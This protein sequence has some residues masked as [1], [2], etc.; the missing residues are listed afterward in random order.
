MKEQFTKKPDWS[1]KQKKVL[2]SEPNIIVSGCAGSGKTLLAC[3]IAMRH[4]KDKNVVILVNTLSLRAFIKEYVNSFGSNNIA[5]FHVFQWRDRHKFDIII[6]DEYQD[7]S[8]NDIKS[9]FLS[10]KIGAYIFGDIEQ[11]LFDTTLNSDSREKVLDIDS[12]S[13]I[14]CTNR[15]VLTENFRISE[16]NKNFISSLNRTNSLINSS[17]STGI[18]PT[19]LGFNSDDEELDWLKE[20]LLTND[21]FTNIG[22]LLKNN[23]GSIRAYYS[24][25]RVR[26]IKVYGI[27]ELKNFL[28]HNGINCGYKHR[29]DDHLI[30]SD[31]INVNLMTIHSAKGLQFDCVILPFSNISNNSNKPNLTY[32]GLTRGS[33]QI[34]I[35]YSGFIS[36]DY[37]A[38]L[39][40]AR[41]NEES[42]HLVPPPQETYEG[43]II[44]SKNERPS[45]EQH[46]EIIKIFRSPDKKGFVSFNGIKV[47]IDL[48]DCDRMPSN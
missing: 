28:E 10:A 39:P 33:I 35:T 16:E 41:T 30:F 23:E 43:N 17:F 48:S 46:M 6:I 38:F 4:S 5:V 24:N 11:G 3:H 22:I 42:D 26:K 40:E 34:I 36:R 47:E 25:K 8:V 29:T 9:F 21:K 7:F 18:K 31:K 14:E 44:K 37:L 20:F 15:F 27:L 45:L 19:I 12:L 1:S 2:E 32:V 13:K